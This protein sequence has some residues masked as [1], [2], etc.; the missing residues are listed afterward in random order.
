MSH[1]LKV[2]DLKYNKSKKGYT[3]NFSNGI[4][5]I[6]LFNI[7]LDN[8]M[9]V[10]EFN[11]MDAQLS[12]VAKEEY[13]IFQVLKDELVIILVKGAFHPISYHNL[14]KVTDIDYIKDELYKLYLRA[15]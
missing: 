7:S 14:I 9:E 5:G 11:L 2:T 10:V 3:L 15:K 4:Y 12:S 13:V 1:N 6:K 8:L